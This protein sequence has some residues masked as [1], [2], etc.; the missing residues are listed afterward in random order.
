MGGGVGQRGNGARVFQHIIGLAR[1]RSSN[2]VLNRFGVL[3]D[4]GCPTVNPRG[5]VFKF[6]LVGGVTEQIIE[7]GC[8]IQCKQ[9]H[10]GI[11]ISWERTDFFGFIG[12][13]F[14]L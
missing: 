8:L 10:V 14:L 7:Q 6:L 4:G 12:T 2:L 9:R 3:W 1:D 11:K 13:F 5:K